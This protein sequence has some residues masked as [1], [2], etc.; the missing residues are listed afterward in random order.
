MEDFDNLSVHPD[1]VAKKVSQVNMH[2]T[3]SKNNSNI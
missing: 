1:P 3:L 2:L